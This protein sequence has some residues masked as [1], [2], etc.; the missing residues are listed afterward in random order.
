MGSQDRMNYTV[1]GERVNLASRLCS[2]A[3]AGEVLM[4]EATLA[5]LRNRV[6]VE[7]KGEVSLKGFSNPVHVYRLNAVNSDA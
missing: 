3:E 6:R 2:V 5:K 4:D 1:L 7:P